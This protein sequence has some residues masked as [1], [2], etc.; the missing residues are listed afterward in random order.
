MIADKLL[1]SENYRRLCNNLYHNW[2]VD[3]NFYYTISFAGETMAPI[4]A[5]AHDGAGQLFKYCGKEFLLHIVKSCK[6]KATAEPLKEMIKNY[7]EFVKWAE[8]ICSEF[9]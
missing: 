4:A 8:D 1:T 9:M 3:N 6:D 2:T 5:D 7:D